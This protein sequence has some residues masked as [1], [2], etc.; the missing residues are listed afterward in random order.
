MEKLEHILKLLDENKDNEFIVSI[1]SSIENEIQNILNK[2]RKC[3]SLADSEIYFNLLDKVQFILAKKAFKE[4]IELPPNLRKF[5]Y[6]FDR[7]DDVASKN[8]L[9]STIKSGGNYFN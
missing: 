8:Y 2:V 1:L 6:D 9:F 7:L 5:V 3:N 4:K